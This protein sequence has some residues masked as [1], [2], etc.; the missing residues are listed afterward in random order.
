LLLP[1]IS[2]ELPW[3]VR[4]MAQL[5]TSNPA[6]RRILSEIRKLVR[7]SACLSLRLIACCARGSSADACLRG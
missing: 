3:K 4:S 1:L 2:H 6:I 5:N 7:R